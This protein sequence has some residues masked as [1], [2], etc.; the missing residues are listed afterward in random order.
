MNGVQ[1][2]D[3]IGEGGEHDFTLDCYDNNVIRG[4]AG[5]YREGL[6]ELKVICNEVRKDQFSTRSATFEVKRECDGNIPLIDTKEKKTYSATCGT[7]SLAIGVHGRVNSGY[8][9]AIGLICLDV[10]RTNVPVAD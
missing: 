10:V 5:V 3:T 1:D 2:T 8:L 4:I 7:M 9:T 6:C